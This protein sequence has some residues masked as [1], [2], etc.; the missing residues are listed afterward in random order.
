MKNKR[1]LRFLSFAGLFSSMLLTSCADMFEE[2][3]PANNLINFVYLNENNK[4]ETALMLAQVTDYIF[5]ADS[6]LYRV[7]SKIQGT[8]I[9]SRAID[10]PDGQWRVLS[11]A[12]AHIN[13]QLSPYTVGKTHMRDFFLE[14]ISKD[15]LKDS[16]PD[17]I[18]NSENLYFS[19]L[20]LEVK[21]GLPKQRPT[22]YY[23]PVHAQLTVFVTWADKEDKATEDQKL[24]AVLRTVA[25]GCKFISQEKTDAAYK[26]P[27]SVPFPLLREK[28][29]RV[30]LYPSDEAFRF[31]VVSMR[32]ETGKAPHLQLMNGTVP[33]TKSLDLNRFFEANNIDLSNTRI[34]NFR[35]SVRIEK[36][37]VVISPID[38]LAWDVEYI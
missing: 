31:D 6:I 25:G 26:I 38:I 2:R 23:T 32:F 14:V 11:L 36:F 20:K 1:M 34:Q 19:A 16:E 7:D 21:N 33:L 30:P 28:Q 8:R 4:D 27:Y 5:D 10:L 9:Q 24:A 12:N 18:G 22:G 35:L 17:Y 29:Q 15:L 13:S 3:C 37:K